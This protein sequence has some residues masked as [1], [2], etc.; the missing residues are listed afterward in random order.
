MRLS[1]RGS[2]GEE[3]EEETNRRRVLPIR[4]IHG[5]PSKSS[6][7]P[8][9]DVPSLHCCFPPSLF[10]NKCA[11]PYPAPLSHPC[12]AP[13]RNIVFPFSLRKRR[14]DLFPFFAHK[15]GYHSLQWANL[16]CSAPNM[17][18]IPLDYLITRNGKWPTANGKSDLES[19]K[20]FNKHW[21][22]LVGFK[23]LRDLPE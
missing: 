19:F 21:L 15:H 4:S 16:F 8:L 22:G 11:S 13:L 1:R 6:N 12:R 5:C 10:L 17:R 14:A 7:Y 23:L 20:A 9:A 18:P 2:G 3:K